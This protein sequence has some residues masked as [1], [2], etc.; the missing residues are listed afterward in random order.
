MREFK[1]FRSMVAVIAASVL[2]LATGNSRALTAEGV[3]AKVKDS[4]FTVYSLDFDTKRSKAR[5]SAVAI[6]KTQ[7][8]TNCHVALAGNYLLVKIGEQLKVARL[9]F[10]DDKQDLCLL[11]VPNTHFS[12]VKIRKSDSVKI[13]EVV[14]TVGNPEGTEK[15]LSQGIISNR[16]PV[17]NGVWL[18][19]DARI[20]FGSSGGGLFDQE[21]QLIGI[22]AKMG[23]NF[24]FAIPTEWVLNVL[25]PSQLRVAEI[26]DVAEQDQNAATPTPAPTPAPQAGAKP[27]YSSAYANLKLLGTYGRDQISLYRNN[28]ECFISIPGRGPQN[29]PVGMTIWNPQHADRMVIFA[30]APS[31]ESALELLLRSIEEGQADGKSSNNYRS[32]NILN[33]DGQSFNLFGASSSTERYAYFVAHF[34][35]SPLAELQKN[36][37]FFVQFHDADPRIGNDKVVYSLDGFAQALEAFKQQCQTKPAVQ[38]QPETAPQSP[39]QSQPQTQ[40]QPQAS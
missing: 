35:R 9:T 7:L 12:A 37:D 22:T 16:L 33:L 26:K 25:N 1:N 30:S 32:D 21:G 18:Q 14:F 34:D 11:E 24:A 38:P 29:K 3:Y 19:T 8:A 20:Y 13:G 28:A 17:K 23:G 2:M 4:V 36:R 27:D 6:G 40:S 5:G 15:S 31:M 39:P 10:K